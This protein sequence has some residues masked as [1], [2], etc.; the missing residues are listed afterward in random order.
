MGRHEAALG[1]LREAR[2]LAGRFDHA[3]LSAWSQVQLGLLALAHG[4]TRRGPG[5]AG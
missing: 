5:A 4:P 1:Y 2:A 3:G